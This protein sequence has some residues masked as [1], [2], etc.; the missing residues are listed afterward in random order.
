NSQVA[1]T[2]VCPA[3]GNTVGGV[4]CAML[5][6]AMFT[7]TTYAGASIPL[8]SLIKAGLTA[9]HDDNPAATNKTFQSGVDPVVAAAGNFYSAV[10]ADAIPFVKV[11]PVRAGTGTAL[12]FG[13]AGTV[14]Q[15]LAVA[16][17]GHESDYDA[18]CN[19]YIA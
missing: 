3:A 15:H 10:A 13:G 7:A 6:P 9:V 18:G 5:D 2:G 14:E 4:Y 17:G 8:N 11:A 16:L 12:G 19:D 1:G